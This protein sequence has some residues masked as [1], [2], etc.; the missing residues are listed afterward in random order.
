LH[1][2]RLIRRRSIALLAVVGCVAGTAPSAAAAQPP[3]YNM[4][5]TWTTGYLEGSARESANG[6]YDITQMNMATGSFSGTAETLG[7]PFA[8]EGVESGS[9]AQLT[10]KEGSYTAYDTLHLSVLASGHVGGN[11][12]FNEKEFMET[13]TGF[14]AEQNR[15]PSEEVSAK[16]K[17]ESERKAKE[18]AEREKRPSA[19]SIIC[20]Y[21]FATSENTCVASVGDGGAGT[22]VTPMGAVT[23]TTSSGGFGS[24]ATCTVA[25]TPSS[26]SVAS[27]SLVYFTASSG[28]PDITAT[29]GGDAHHAGSSGRTQFLGMGTE[30]TFEAPTGPAGQY[31]AE[32]ALNTEVP[33]AGTTVEGAAQGP[34]RFPLPAPIV[35]P[36]VSSALD[37]TSAADLRIAEALATEVDVGDAQNA[38]KVSELDGAIEKLDARAV[39]LTKSASTAERADGQKLLKDATDTT[40]AVTKMLKLQGEYAKDALEGT[41]TAGQADQRIERLDAQAVELLKSPSPADQAKG[42]AVLDEA[43]Q[44]LEAL[45][46]AAKQKG[47]TVKKVIGNASAATARRSKLAR[48]RAGRVKSLGHVTMHNVAAGKL[49]LK[50]HLNRVELSKLAG[51][52]SSVTVYVRVDMILP[53]GL[54]KGGV[55]RSFVERVTLKR[56][57]RAQAHAKH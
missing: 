45:L 10:L 33:I 4:L 43:N 18:E 29:Y 22:P 19:T 38:A 1:R 52:R 50:L 20:N 28:L 3:S 44:T 5:G 46:K 26:P 15:L 55:P 53:S 49:R 32:V 37:A 8:L 47:E 24:G 12:T 11:G 23:F 57:T 41:R 30:G 40:Q 6:S 35:L 54:F 39:E 21:E 51:R 36:G 13:G 27:C 42:Q 7:V 31:P 14:W 34:D 16:G 17:E 25:P 48:I 56:T 9:L 2:V